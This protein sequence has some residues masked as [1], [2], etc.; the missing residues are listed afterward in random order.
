MGYQKHLRGHLL[1]GGLQ[2][3]MVFPDIRFIYTSKNMNSDLI[4]E[5]KISMI[6]CSLF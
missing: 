3:S 5:R 2:N 6:K 4:I 1:N